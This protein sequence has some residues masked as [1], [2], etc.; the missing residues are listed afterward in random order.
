VD[1]KS[2]VCRFFVFFFAFDSTDGPARGSADSRD[3]LAAK[4]QPLFTPGAGC[5]SFL[6]YSVL[7]L[8]M[9]PSIA[10]CRL[11]PRVIHT[12][13]PYQKRNIDICILASDPRIHAQIYIHPWWYKWLTCITCTSDERQGSEALTLEECRLRVWNLYEHLGGRQRT[14]M[15][16]W[17][18]TSHSR[19]HTYKQRIQLRA[20]L[21]TV[22]SSDCL[23]RPLLMFPFW[24]TFDAV[25]SHHC[26]T[27]GQWGNTLLWR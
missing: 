4:C 3:P 21:K 8:M 20:H 27:C 5:W 13:F 10:P 19:Q 14:S 17:A 18:A 7:L 23:L 11:V 2:A 16:A 15:Q 1:G 25:D 26:W 22:N 9:R 12:S 6:L 24:L